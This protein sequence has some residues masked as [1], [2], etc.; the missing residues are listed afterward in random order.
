C[1]SIWFIERLIRPRT[2][3]GEVDARLRGSVA[4]QALFKFYSGLPKRTGGERVD[5]ERLDET[6]E[7]LRECLSEAI[8]DCVW[9]E[10]RGARRR[11][12]GCGGR[13][14]PARS[15]SGGAAARWPGTDAPAACPA[16]RRQRTA[17]VSRSATTST[18]TSSGRRPSGRRSTRP[19]LSSE[20]APGTCST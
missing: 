1:S 2:I 12:A 13:P 18:R 19:A 17:P 14:C 15:R 20:F 16:P 10:I 11:G 5:P 7:F 3:D 6:L 4:H 8:E 9:I